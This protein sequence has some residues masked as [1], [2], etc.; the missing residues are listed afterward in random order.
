MSAVERVFT[1]H[2]CM[3]TSNFLKLVKH[4]R[5]FALLPSI[6]WLL[7]FLSPLFYDIA[8]VLEERI[9]IDVSFKGQYSSSLSLNI[10]INYESLHQSMTTKQSNIL[11]VKGST[12]L[13]AS[14]YNFKRKFTSITFDLNTNSMFLPGRQI[15]Y[16]PT[17][18]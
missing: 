9:D 17:P 8:R 11:N 7:Y 14:T 10:L 16:L 3:G 18:F 6:Q 13:W 12:Q 2:L 15:L 1:G 5:L 4:S